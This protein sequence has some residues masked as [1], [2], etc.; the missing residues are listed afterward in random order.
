[1]SNIHLATDCRF[2]DLKMMYIALFSEI[3][4]ENSISDE[5][6]DWKWTF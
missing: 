3:T 1:M 4:R 2:H 6:N 5:N